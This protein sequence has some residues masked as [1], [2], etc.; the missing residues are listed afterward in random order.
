MCSHKFNEKT[1]FRKP[2]SLRYLGFYA[3]VSTVQITF[4]RKADRFTALTKTDHCGLMTSVYFF[5]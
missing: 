5:A 4:F 3:L 1:I 2:F